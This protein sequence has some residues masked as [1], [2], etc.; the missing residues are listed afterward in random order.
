M[1]WPTEVRVKATFSAWRART[2]QELG[3]LWDKALFVPD[4][5]ILLHCLRHSAEVRE[6]LLSIFELLR[7][8]LWIPYQVGREFHRNRL[9]VEAS[10]LDAYDRITKEMEGHLGRARDSLRQLRAHPSIQVDRE[11]SAIGM[12]EGDFRTRIA[13]ARAEH[14]SAALGAALE[15]VTAVFEGRVGGAP[16][17]ERMAAMRKEGEERYAKRIPPGYKDAKKD[18]PDAEKFGDLI[19]WKDLME[20]AKLTKRPIVFITDDAKEDWWQIHRGAKFGPRPELL[21]EFRAHAVQ[22]FHIYELGQ[23]LRVAAERHDSIP[24]ASV[25]QIERSV[26]EDEEARR[27]QKVRGQ[28]HTARVFSL[29]NERDSIIAALSGVPAASLDWSE[30]MPDKQSLRARLAEVDAELEAVRLLIQDG[31]RA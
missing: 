30:S 29:E 28:E 2:P 11:L 14:P 20:K 15:R 10:A 19:I 3:A 17:S 16:T 4:A 12:F 13:K 9:E 24:R 22:D 31:P 18:A 25:D 6:K 7:E 5:N 27:L 8:S 21:E 1:A 23:F 26:H